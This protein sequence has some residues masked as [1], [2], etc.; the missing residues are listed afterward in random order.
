[1]AIRGNLALEIDPANH[2]LFERCSCCG[3]HT[4]RVWG[5]VNE[6]GVTIAAYFVEWT[7]GQPDHIANFDLIIDRWGDDAGPECRQGVSLAFRHLATGPAFMVVN[8]SKRPI[9]SSTLLKGALDRDQVVDQP[10]SEVA[11]AICDAIFVRDPRIAG[12]TL[13]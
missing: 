10:I 5:Y 4:E 12:L 13:R 11:F 1:M 3:E 6:D 8:A 2:R 9:G 7:P